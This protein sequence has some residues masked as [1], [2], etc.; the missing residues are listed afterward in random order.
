MFMLTIISQTAPALWRPIIDRGVYISRVGNGNGQSQVQQTSGLWC[1]CVRN[2]RVTGSVRAGRE[3]LIHACR[4]GGH[5]RALYP[6]RHALSI[7][8]N[9]NSKNILLVMICVCIYKS[10]VCCVCM[11]ACVHVRVK[12]KR[13]K[14]ELKWVRWVSMK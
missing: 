14:E 3:Q 13:V 2:E 1:G 12:R 10:C 5:R 6:R 8:P 7:H 9:T 4:H 11:C